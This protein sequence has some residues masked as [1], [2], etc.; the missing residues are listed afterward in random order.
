[1]C[2]YCIRTPRNAQHIALDGLRG[3]ANP[4][5]ILKEKTSEN[6]PTILPVTTDF[7]YVYADAEFVR[8]K[9]ESVP[10]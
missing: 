5:R 7:N 2:A 4:K 3:T 1:M 8:A 6:A 9:T 10:C